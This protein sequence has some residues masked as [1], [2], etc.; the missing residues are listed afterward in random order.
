MTLADKL[1]KLENITKAQQV[2]GTDHLRLAGISY[3]DGTIKGVMDHIP[4]AGGGADILMPGFIENT[5]NLVVTDVL[6]GGEKYEPQ[7]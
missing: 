6:T 1:D 2:N 5:S 3:D 4:K 7:S